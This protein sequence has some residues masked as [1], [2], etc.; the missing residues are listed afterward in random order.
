MDQEAL[1]IL[2][3]VPNIGIAIWVIWQYHRTIKTLLENQQKLIDQL[4][5]LH[6]PQDVDRQTSLVLPPR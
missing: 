4:M 2:T 3:T 6:P 1:S 5:S